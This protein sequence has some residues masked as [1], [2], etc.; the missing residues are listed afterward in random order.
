[1]NAVDSENI[2]VE[3]LTWDGATATLSKSRSAGA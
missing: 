3:K 2:K 1:M